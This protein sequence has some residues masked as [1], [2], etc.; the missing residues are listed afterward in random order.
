[1]SDIVLPDNF[2]EV[3]IVPIDQP[4]TLSLSVLPADDQP[5][6]PESE[7]RWT[8]LCAHNPA[9]FNGR[10][11]ALDAWHTQQQRLTARVAHY[12]QMVAPDP[13]RS[14]IVQIGVT[15]VFLAR[16]SRASDNEPHVLLAQ[17]THRTTVYPDQWELAPSGGIDP[18]PLA[19]VTL[20]LTAWLDALK[21]E[22]HEELGLDIAPCAIRTPMMCFDPF[23]PSADLVCIVHLTAQRDDVHQ[24]VTSHLGSTWEYSAAQWIPTSRLAEAADN[25]AMT[26]IPPSRAIL[27]ALACD[28]SF[29]KS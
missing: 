5:A 17:R 9:L 19:P 27:R 8:Q 24:A 26:I 2:S 4:N 15:G 22:A 14:R 25:P 28:Q 18:P 11:L 12:Q 21:Q 20:N 7:H 6:S 10:I 23:A 16:N 13:G 1:M 3:L 29:L